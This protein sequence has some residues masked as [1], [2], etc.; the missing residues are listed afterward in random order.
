MALIAEDYPSPR[1][2]V[3]MFCKTDDHEFHLEATNPFTP[4]TAFAVVLTGFD[5]KLCCQ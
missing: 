4:L 1:D 3:L 2:Y 5:F